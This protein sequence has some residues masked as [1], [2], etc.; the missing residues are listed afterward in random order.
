MEKGTGSRNVIVQD[1]CGK[2][3]QEE[4]ISTKVDQK[5]QPSVSVKAQENTSDGSLQE[6]DKR[7][8][9]DEMKFQGEVSKSAREVNLSELDAAVRIQSAYRGYDVRRWRPLE[10]LRKV[11][12]VHDQMQ[13]LKKQLQ[14]L[15]ASSKQLT[16][17][18]QVA[19][20]ETIMNL[21][22]SLDSI[23][24][25]C[26]FSLVSVFPIHKKTCMLGDR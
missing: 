7:T 19:I 5:V 18:E 14:G 8:E 20:N 23:Q 3:A 4:D 26:F 11:K 13:D 17:K 22:L 21:L 10:K 24:V 12:K 9:E 25:W 15:E 2:P 1:A 16:V 6:C